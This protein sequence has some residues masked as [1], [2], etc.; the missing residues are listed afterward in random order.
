V[1]HLEAGFYRLQLV[2][3]NKK[4]DNHQRMDES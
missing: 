1:M 2:H 4:S 3:M